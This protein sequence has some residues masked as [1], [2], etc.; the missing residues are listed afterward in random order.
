MQ[1]SIQE[2]I[3]QEI[4]EGIKDKELTLITIPDKGESGIVWIK[5]DKEFRYKGDLFDVVKIRYKDQKRLY[6]C[7]NDHKEQQLIS[8]F[9]KTHNSK[10]ESAKKLKRNFNYGFYTERFIVIKNLFPADCVFSS[11][12]GL[13]TPNI[14]DI[15]S[16]PPKSA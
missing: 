10:K 11:S 5:Q 16:P 15:H 2:K 13:Y 14:I 3:E 9:N 12:T 8:N 6:Y 4:K 1:F 7:L